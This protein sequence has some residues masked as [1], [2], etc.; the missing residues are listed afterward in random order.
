MGEQLLLVALLGL[1][2]GSISLTLTRS[3][4]FRPLRLSLMH[5]EA[6]YDGAIP[7]L[8][9][10]LHELSR[11]CYCMCHWVAIAAFF[12]FRPVL[13]SQPILNALLCIF[14]TV[15]VSVLVAGLLF[16]CASVIEPA[17]DA[18]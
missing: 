7:T 9:G 18:K 17:K 11:C 1:A 13:Y 5:V 16:A 10:Y 12:S 8:F 6:R 15:T 3:K 4:L 2:S 14:V